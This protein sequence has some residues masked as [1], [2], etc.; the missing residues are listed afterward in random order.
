MRIAA[1]TNV[2]VRYLTGDDPAQAEAAARALEAADTVYVPLVVLCE[3]VWVLKRAYGFSAP[4]IAETLRRLLESDTIEVDQPAAAAGL[5]V[6]D[7]GG[8]FADGVI[9]HEAARA[10]CALVTFDR[11]LAGASTDGT[12]VLLATRPP[13]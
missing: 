6:L 12:V 8:D 13:G 3:T 10:D 5:R 9:L 2:L 7:A 1:D 4:T 11:R